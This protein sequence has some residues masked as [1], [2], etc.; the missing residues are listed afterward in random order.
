MK[1]RFSGGFPSLGYFVTVLTQRSNLVNVETLRS[2]VGAL[3]REIGMKEMGSVMV[4]ELPSEIFGTKAFSVNQPLMTSIISLDTWPE[5]DGFV[6]LIHSC[7]PFSPR[8]VDRFIESFF[9]GQ[10]E[11]LKRTVVN[12]SCADWNFILARFWAKF[13]RRLKDWFECRPVRTGPAKE[14]LEA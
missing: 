13:R 1:K 4:G 3:C 14:V 9:G 5:S 2:F 7:Q 6:L 10:A 12:H 11:I 8:A